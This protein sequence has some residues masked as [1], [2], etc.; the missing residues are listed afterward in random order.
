[1]V[2]RPKV[3]LEKFAASRAATFILYFAIFW[4]VAAATTLEFF[5]KWGLREA[6]PKYSIVMMLDGTA[7][8][9]YC[10]NRPR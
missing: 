9:L 10:R 2:S 4:V 7:H 6:S 8:R 3:T 1:M 5:A